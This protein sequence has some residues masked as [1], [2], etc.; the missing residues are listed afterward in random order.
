MKRK[1][2]INTIYS[3]LCITGFYLS[4]P[5]HN[6]LYMRVVSVDKEDQRHPSFIANATD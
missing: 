5:C 4:T 2:Q 6:N 3:V 1:V